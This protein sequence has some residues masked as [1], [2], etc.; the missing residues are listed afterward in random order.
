MRQVLVNLIHNAVKF[1]NPG[2]K[3]TVCTGHADGSV[4]VEVSDTGIGI[5]KTDLPHI[6]ERFF[7]GDRSRTGSGTGLGL[8]IARNIITAHG[9]TIRAQSTEGKGS[10]FTITLPPGS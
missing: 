5:S 9:G 4:S 10:T 8:A 2:G 3:I 1:T 7:K 6:F